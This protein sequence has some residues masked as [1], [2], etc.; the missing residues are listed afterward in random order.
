MPQKFG[1]LQARE[2]KKPLFTDLNHI[3]LYLFH[4]ETPR[5][6]RLV[7][8]P[9]LRS[10]AEDIPNCPF[11]NFFYKKTLLKIDD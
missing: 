9:S 10:E 4:N 5:L 6:S 8:K 1:F 7:R 2:L 3:N 11:Q